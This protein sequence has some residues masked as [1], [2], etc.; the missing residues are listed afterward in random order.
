MAGIL[1]LGRR[2]EDAV[3][4]ENELTET[5]IVNKV[6]DYAVKENV[7]QFNLCERGEISRE[8]YGDDIKQY[9]YKN[10][11]VDADAVE[12][13]YQ[14]FGSFIWG[15]YILEPLIDD[16]Q[17][18]DIRIVDSS[19]IYI[20]KKG[21]RYPAEIKFA[22]DK[23]YERFIERCI[24]RNHINLGAN[25]SIAIWTDKSSDDWI[26]RFEAITK[27]L[28]ANAYTTIHIRKHPKKKK[29]MDILT[30][31]GENLLTEDMSVFIKECQERGES[32]LVCGNNGGGKTTLLN[33]MIENIPMQYSIFC[34]QESDELFSLKEREFCA[35]HVI[36]AKG[37]SKISYSLKNLAQAGLTMDTDVYMLGEIK[38]DEAAEML[39]AVHTGAI[40][41]ASTHSH[42]IPDAYVRLFDYIRRITNY[43]MQEIM[44]MLRYIKY[45]IYVHR[46]RVMDI[47]EAVWNE[48]KKELEY[49]YIFK[50]GKRCDDGLC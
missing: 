16:P 19:H 13:V 23:D 3:K 11:D 20:K 2:E 32:F 45:G 41:Y 47:A 8:Q 35:Y 30:S 33:A 6:I 50:D 1:G 34:A 25:N 4:Q 44:Y 38:G 46:Y 14:Q 5:D 10:Y 28:A 26:L 17:V 21:I 37:E 36:E 15:Y 22:D 43:S 39:R 7:T 31:P 42:S 9:I 18:S 49:R 48:E 27:M 40:S 29:T 12:R 24:L